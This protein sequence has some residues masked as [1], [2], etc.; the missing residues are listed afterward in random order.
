[1]TNGEKA[2]QEL[3]YELD[4]TYP[5]KY[6]SVFDYEN[7]DIIISFYGCYLDNK[8]IEYLVS[9]F[10]RYSEGVVDLSV[11]VVKAILLRLEELN[12]TIKEN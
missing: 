1:M 7:N 4:T 6:R 5:A 12:Q 8:I 11:D 3:G 10:D 2:L 9:V